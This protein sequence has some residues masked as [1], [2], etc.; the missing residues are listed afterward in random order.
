MVTRVVPQQV[1]AFSWLTTPEK[2]LYLY[3]NVSHTPQLTNLVDSVFHVYRDFDQNV[4]EALK[5]NRNTMK[6]L[7]IAFNQ[8]YL[9]DDRTYEPFISSAYVEAT[10]QPPLQRHLVRN[11]PETLRVSGE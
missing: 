1:E 9:K 7:A 8:V 6:T 10:S 4:E 2:Y 3:E 11:L 5:T